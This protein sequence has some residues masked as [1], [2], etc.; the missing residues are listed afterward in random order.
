[1]GCG[2][3]VMQPC[4]RRAKACPSPPKMQVCC[5]CVRHQAGNM[6]QLEQVANMYEM[7]SFYASLCNTCWD[8]CVHKQFDA[9]TAVEQTHQKE[10][11]DRMEPF[12]PCVRRCL[13]RIA[14]ANM[15]ITEEFVKSIQEM[16]EKRAAM[17]AAM[18]M[19]PG[20]SR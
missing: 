20:Q 12:D 16:A 9:K 6:D 1:M 2:P 11:R 3:C 5:A 10:K 18:G 17:D 13:G 15:D 4:L 8:T 14:S 19:P 7:E